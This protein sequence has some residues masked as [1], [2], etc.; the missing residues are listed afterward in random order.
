MGWR[1]DSR[2]SQPVEIVFEFDKVREFRSMDIYC[3]NQFTKEVQ[4]SVVSP[5]IT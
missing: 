3:N 1:N 2:N 4:V 5:S